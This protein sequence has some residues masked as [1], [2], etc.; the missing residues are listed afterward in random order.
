M[1]DKALNMNSKAINK[2]SDK[3]KVKCS[4]N[5]HSAY[6]HRYKQAVKKLSTKIERQNG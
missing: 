1:R 4:K 3:L 6:T 2:I 5:P